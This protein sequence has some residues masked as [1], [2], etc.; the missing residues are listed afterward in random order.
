[1]IDAGEVQLLDYSTELLIGD[2]LTRK[3]AQEK[4][5]AFVDAA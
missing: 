5:T 4:L 3:L 2:E 1:M